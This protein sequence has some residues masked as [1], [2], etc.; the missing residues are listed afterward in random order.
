M[1]RLICILIIFGVT[2][3]ASAWA[4]EAN[5]DASVKNEIVALE[6]RSWVAWKGHDGKFFE[7][8]LT[9]DHVEVEPGGVIGK[10]EVVASVAGPACSVESYALGE[11]KFTRITADVAALTYSAS[12]KATC[13]GKSVPSPAWTTSI[14]VRR[15]G[16][17]QNMLY[18]PTP[19]S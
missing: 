5:D 15:D 18:Q 3:G 10:A 19:A 2:T 6:Q 13:S 4:A 12:Q 1:I 17:W 16:R 9:S 14:Y 11:M 8:F 7:R